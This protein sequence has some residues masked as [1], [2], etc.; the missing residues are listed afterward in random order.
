[1]ALLSNWHFMR[2]FRAVVAGWAFFEFARTNDW[3]IL[4]IGSFFALQAIFD[5]GCCGPSGCSTSTTPRHQ[6]NSV[7]EV[8]FEEIK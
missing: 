2:I 4:M 6:V 7:E 3:M 1:M 5:F 8:D